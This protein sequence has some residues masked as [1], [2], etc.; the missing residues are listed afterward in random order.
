MLKESLF[1]WPPLGIVKLL[2]SDGFCQ[3][4]NT[5]SP[6]P[7]CHS[8]IISSTPSLPCLLPSAN[9][10]IT[11]HTQWHCAF[12]HHHFWHSM[13][14][15]PHPRLAPL[16]AFLMCGVASAWLWLSDLSCCQKEA[17]R[18]TLKVSGRWHWSTGLL[19]PGHDRPRVPSV[20]KTLTEGWLTCSTAL[21]LRKPQISLFQKQ[22]IVCEILAYFGSRV[23][24]DAFQDREKSEEWFVMLCLFS[25][26][27]DVLYIIYHKQF[28]K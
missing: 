12:S 16:G 19:G 5:K 8:V 25:F 10:H 27:W 24:M 2:N 9:R 23:I 3:L 22:K 1:F 7:L 20:S 28:S 11:K 13:R 17:T 18:S 26:N 15:H 6:S 4:F 21:L 14:R